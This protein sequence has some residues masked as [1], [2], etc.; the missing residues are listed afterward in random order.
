[1][2]NSCAGIIL[3]GGKNTRFSGTNKAFLRVG[4]QR[5]LDRI[6]DVFRG[7]FQEIVLVTND[8]LE[9]LEWDLTVVT[10]LFPIQSA[11]TG[12]HAGL[13]FMTTPYAFFVACDTPF[14]QKNLIEIVLENIEPR[15]DVVIPETSEG[16]QP[17]CSVY[18]RQ[19]L[20]PIAQ[21][22]KKQELKIDRVFN[23]LRTRKIPE[24]ILRKQ[25]P[26]LISFYNINTPEDLARAEDMLVKL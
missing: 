2:Q 19:C 14:I 6:Y 9:Y 16:L 4:A 8:P 11:L 15:I 7:L 26:D 5:I 1:M 21:Q 25:D 3:A 18:S 17:L 24:A 10:D 22:L 20:K 13:F 12:I 23:R